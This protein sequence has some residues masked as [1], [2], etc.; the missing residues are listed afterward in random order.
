[1]PLG[2]RM[3]MAIRAELLAIES[4]SVPSAAATAAFPPRTATILLAAAAAW[5]KDDVVRVLLSESASEP[6]WNGAAALISALC[7]ADAA[8]ENGS[9]LL[10]NAKGVCGDLGA[11][12]VD[13]RANEAPLVLAA[14]RGRIGALAAMLETPDIEVDVMNHAALR[15]AA[16]EDQEA[17]VR[18]LLGKYTAE[19][20]DSRL[21]AFDALR[22]SLVR[23][24]HRMAE[25][26]LAEERVMAAM[27][28]ALDHCAPKNY[29]VDCFHEDTVRLLLGHGLPLDEHVV[30]GIAEK[31]TFA[32]WQWID[33]KG[34]LP[35][36]VSPRVSGDAF[37]RAIAHGET[38]M[39]RAILAKYDG[40]LDAALAKEKADREEIEEDLAE[41]GMPFAFVHELA[42]PLDIARDVLPILNGADEDGLAAQIILGRVVE[43]DDLAAWLADADDAAVAHV[44]ALAVQFRH[45]DVVAHLAKTDRVAP[46]GAHALMRAMRSGHLQLIELLLDA[47]V[48]HASIA[49]RFRDVVQAVCMFDLGS[50]ALRMLNDDRYD[51]T[52]MFQPFYAAAGGARNDAVMQTILSHA[53]THA[54]PAALLQR[55][56]EECVAFDWLP[57]L[58]ALCRAAPQIAQL[59]LPMRTLSMAARRRHAD[60]IDW[61]FAH[62]NLLLLP[63]ATK[64]ELLFLLNCA[65]YSQ[66]GGILARVVL[67]EHVDEQLLDETDEWKLS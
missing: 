60:V 11:S 4:G 36:T 6:H 13:R 62:P 54:L 53:T 10:I 8:E 31:A 34:A 3:A 57:Q 43:K 35:A 40:A 5:R 14:R 15:Y 46:L 61:L 25:V 41:G 12:G 39:A 45:A 20:F 65:I 32:T 7:A 19:M 64:E 22:S 16:E 24:Q 1:M 49:A 18:L 59:R 56:L 33:D 48:L 47:P 38:L 67:S 58:Q 21:G 23:K 29:W 55:P 42:P 44:L 51:A 37:L 66:H 30:R 28:D 63:T 26:L 9:A 2:S 17:A 27:P 52:T 50:L